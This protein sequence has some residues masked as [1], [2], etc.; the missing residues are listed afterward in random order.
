MALQ[1]TARYNFINKERTYFLSVK[2][3]DTF[4]TPLNP[5]TLI[6][7]YIFHIIDSTLFILHLLIRRI[8]LTLKEHS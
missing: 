5:I 4:F 8:P 2:N 3:L 7:E 1:H 6:D